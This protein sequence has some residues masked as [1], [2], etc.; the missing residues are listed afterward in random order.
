[1]A[2]T[3]TI[4]NNAAGPVTLEPGYPLGGI[5]TKLDRTELGRGEKAILTLTAGKGA[6]GG[7]YYVQVAPTGEPL[8]I[9]VK[10]Q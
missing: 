5:E 2:E 9:N 8:H 4:V 7:Y 6:S 3:V 1:V 10:V